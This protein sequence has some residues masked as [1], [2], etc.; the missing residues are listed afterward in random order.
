VT[1]A[2]SHWSSEQGLPSLVH[3]VPRVFLASAGQLGPLP[4]Q[5]SV[6]S[7]SA[8]ALRHTFDAGMNPSAGHAVE[9]PVQ[10]SATS[11]APLADRQTLPALPAGCVQSAL[12]PSH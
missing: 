2:P 10:A 5:F 7:H 1:F 6:T 12:E 8:T 3:A 4:G 9:V 11:Q